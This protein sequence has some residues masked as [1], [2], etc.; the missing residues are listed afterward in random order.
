MSYY[1]NNL[2]L[3]KYYA[4]KGNYDL[5]NE[6]CGTSGKMLFELK[7]DRGAHARVATVYGTEYRLFTYTNFYDNKTFKEVK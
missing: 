1:T 6:P 5:G 4:F 7:T 3:K 2:P